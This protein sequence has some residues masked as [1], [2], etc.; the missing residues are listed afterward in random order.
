MPNMCVACTFVHSFVFLAGFRA[1]R[2]CAS[3]L[4]C[5]CMHDDGWHTLS[6]SH[7]HT[8]THTTQTHICICM[9]I[10]CTLYIHDAIYKYIACMYISPSGATGLDIR[11]LSSCRQSTTSRKLHAWRGTW[12]CRA[13]SPPCNLPKDS[14]ALETK[15]ETWTETSLCL[16]HRTY[17]PASLQD[18]L[19]PSTRTPLPLSPSAL[20]RRQ[21]LY[22]CKAD[23]IQSSDYPS[24]ATRRGHAS[25]S[26]NNTFTTTIATIFPPP[27]HPG[28]S[29]LP[30][31]LPSC[32][33]APCPSRSWRQRLYCQQEVILLQC[34]LSRPSPNNPPLLH[35]PSSCPCTHPYKPAL[36]LTP[37]HDGRT[38]IA[39]HLAPQLSTFKRQTAQLRCP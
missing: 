10:L 14:H 3:T 25:A 21:R 2:L 36:S 9:Y 35:V 38:R 15:T 22:T 19:S 37:V 5:L 26:I 7:T 13:H 32:T 4:L 39:I 1:V 6:L 33:L 16:S 24:R 31:P 8:H 30:L 17:F 20:A 28:P 27:S 34:K 29:W 11:A 12:I 23:T 18:S